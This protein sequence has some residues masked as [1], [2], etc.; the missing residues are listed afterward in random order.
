VLFSRTILVRTHAYVPESFDLRLW[1]VKD[2]EFSSRLLV[3]LSSLQL[4]ILHNVYFEF[5]DIVTT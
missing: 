4:E 3:Y 2:D 5:I 1:I